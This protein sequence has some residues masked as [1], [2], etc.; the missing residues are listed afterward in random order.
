MNIFEI[1]EKVATLTD[2]EKVI[3][4]NLNQGERNINILQRKKCAKI[5][6]YTDEDKGQDMI[7]AAVGRNQY[8]PV[9]LWLP[10]DALNKACETDE[11]RKQGAGE[12]ESN[13]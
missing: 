12:V 10:K 11:A 1:L 5:V 13:D 6:F 9:L 8:S 3:C 4:Q 7:R 2:P